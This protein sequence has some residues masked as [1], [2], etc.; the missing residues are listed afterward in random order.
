MGTNAIVET[1]E[2][3]K[4]RMFKIYKE[5]AEK[6]DKLAKQIEGEY[7]T[8]VD[9]EFVEHDDDDEKHD[10]ISIGEIAATAFNWL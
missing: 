1:D 4:D 3:Y 6:W 5:K 10:L 9:G 8:Y 2:Q 7:G